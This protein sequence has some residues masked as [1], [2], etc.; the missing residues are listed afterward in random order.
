[1]R[2]IPLTVALFTEI[3]RLIIVVYFKEKSKSIKL[4]FF[5]SFKKIS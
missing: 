2:H 4:Y 5:K 3:S 1:M